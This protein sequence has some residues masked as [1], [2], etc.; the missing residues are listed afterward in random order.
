MGRKFI[1]NTINLVTDIIMGTGN[2][3]S[4]VGSAIDMAAISKF[5][6]NQNHQYARSIRGRADKFVMQFPM[7]VSDSVS[8]DTAETVRNQIEL[9]RAVNIKLVLDN[10]PVFD[11]DPNGGFLH[12]IHT[13]VN[14]AESVEGEEEK[15]YSAPKSEL[16]KMNKDELVEVKDLIN[17]SALNDYTLPRAFLESD[18]MNKIK[19]N[20]STLLNE[21][22][23][24]LG[25]AKNDRIAK[26]T[27][28]N[29]N[30]ETVFREEA[31]ELA[32]ELAQ[33]SRPADR[34]NAKG[35]KIPSMQSTGGSTTIDLQTAKTLNNSIPIFINTTINFA[36]RPYKADGTLDMNKV[37][38]REKEVSFGVKAVQHVAQS[39]DIAFF[40]TD[41]TKRSNFFAKLVNFTSGEMNLVKRLF[42]IDKYKHAA[43]AYKRTKN[44]TWKNLLR[45]GDTENFRRY[46]NRFGKNIRDGIIP[47]TTLVISSAE[48]EQIFKKTG[49][50]ISEHV[51]F[52]STL[53]KDLYLQE[54][55]IVDEV[56]QIITRYSDEAGFDK[57]RI[58]SL[59]GG[60]LSDSVKRAGDADNLEKLLRKNL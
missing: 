18:M 33:E 12:Q 8:V 40:L 3:G 52:A 1:L 43:E 55:M 45:L 7:V 28:R 51:G 57:I 5:G 35:E 59:S 54:L 30:S 56:N 15:P 47:T 31:E 27:G 58:N 23:L 13:N 49:Y 19:S 14:I 24:V 44:S 38:Y 21:G 48:E 53:Y 36:I 4:K 22:V 34:Y 11:Y 16:D 6:N 2:R 10:T 42:G 39:Q 25:E 17:E 20:R 60:R 46:A 26:L 37:S 50:K 9:E 29:G 32:Q 41:A